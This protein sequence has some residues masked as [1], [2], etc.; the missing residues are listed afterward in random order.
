MKNPVIFIGM[1]RAGTSMT[2]RLLERLG[3]NVGA[4]K[5]NNNEAMFFL[6]INNW[7]LRQ[8][9]ASWDNPEAIHYLWQQENEILEITEEYVKNLMRSPRAIKFLGLRRYLNLRDIT[10]LNELWGWK[11]PRNTFTLPFWLRIFP[12][13]KIVYIE[14]HGVDVAQSLRTRAKEG[15]KLSSNMYRKYKDFI[16]L[17]PKKSGFINSP[18]CVELQG[19]LSLWEEYM[20]EARNLLSVIPD[21]RVLRLRY[22]EV[23]T[24]PVEHLKQAA[25]FCG[26]D[27][28]Q[29]ELEFVCK[30][31][32]ANRA[33]AYINDKQLKE[34]AHANNAVLTEFGYDANGSFWR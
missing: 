17:R 26:L 24:S 5:E 11:D 14:R 10:M 6:E 31:I 9:G 32:N 3:L 7:L 20:Q 19:G 30:G 1:H 33:Y 16:W 22:E 2:G 23:L 27:V 25:E 15:V 8:G 29:S 12:E 4:Q 34:F 28:K 13:A 21:T 18:R